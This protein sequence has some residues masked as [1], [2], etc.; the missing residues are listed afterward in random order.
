MGLENIT[1]TEAPQ[2]QE[3]KSNMF[4][5]LWGSYQFLN[6]YISM[7]KKKAGRSQGKVEEDGRK[8][9]MWGWCRIN[10]N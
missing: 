7:E 4:S 3:G 8:E 2:A 9:L 10:P 1:V 5:L 6:M